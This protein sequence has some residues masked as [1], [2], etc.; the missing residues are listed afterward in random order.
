MRKIDTLLTRCAVFVGVHVVCFVVFLS[1]T[2]DP[3]NDTP[4]ALTQYASIFS[5]DPKHWLFLT[6]DLLLLRRIGAEMYELA[7]DTQT[8]SEHLVLVDR[9]GKVH[10]RYRWRNHPGELTEMKQAFAELLAQTEPPEEPAAQS[11]KQQ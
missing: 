5:A 10:G 1:I 9:W 3:D 11:P 2:C 4:A 6:G 8:H 7:V